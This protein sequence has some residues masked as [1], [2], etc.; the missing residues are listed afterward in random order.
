MQEDSE[1]SDCSGQ[2]RSSGNIPP[3]GPDFP[4]VQREEGGQ[5]L[6]QFLVRRLNMPESLLHRW[7]R[8]GQIRVNG[9]RCK[10]FARLSNGDMVRLPPFASGIAAKGQAGTF[11]EKSTNLCFLARQ[12]DIAALDK[13]G[14]LP[15]QPGSGHGDC[16]S[17]RLRDSFADAIFKPVPCHRLDRDTSGILLVAMSFA[18]LRQ[19]QEYLRDGKVHKE[20]LAWVEGY[21]PE[22]RDVLLRHYLRKERSNGKTLIRVHSVPVPYGKEAICAIRAIVRGKD[23]SLLQIRLLT[24]RTHQ[25]RAQLAFSGFPVVGDGKYGTS[26]QRLLLHSFR[27]ILP[28]GDEFTSPPPWEGVFLPAEMPEPFLRNLAGADFLSLPI[29]GQTAH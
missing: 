9:R 24:G 21:W 17:G 3:P 27:V 25:I 14:G 13:P 20:Y 22:D 16:I 12:G 2:S 26:F 8:T 10:P 19:T 7:I 4:P 23:K 5:K 1:N 6:L 28:E 29:F 18:A 11:K 15:V